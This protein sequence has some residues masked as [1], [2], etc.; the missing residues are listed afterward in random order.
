MTRNEESSVGHDLVI[1]DESGVITLDYCRDGN[2]PCGDEFC[3]KGSHYIND[4]C[5]CGDLYHA[6]DD[7]DGDD[8]DDVALDNVKKEP[9]VPGF[10]FNTIVS[11][12]YGEFE[13]YPLYSEASYKMPDEGCPGEDFYSRPMV[14]VKRDFICTRDEGCKTSDGRVYPKSEE[15]NISHSYHYYTSHGYSNNKFKNMECVES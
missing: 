4:L 11:N 2:C 1:K 14:V 5:V 9:Y 15:V 7:D 12:N 8:D 13:C 10:D 3:S 6:L